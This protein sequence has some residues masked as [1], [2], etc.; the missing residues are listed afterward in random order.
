MTTPIAPNHSHAA[1]EPACAVISARHNPPARTTPAPTPANTMPLSAGR[2]RR[3]RRCAHH[4]LMWI[5]AHA[6]E[7]PASARSASHVARPSTK[8]IA[9]RRRRSDGERGPDRAVGARALHHRPKRAGQV[10]EIVRR[11]EPAAFRNRNAGVLLHHR[12]NRGKGEAADALRQREG[13]Q[14]RDRNDPAGVN[15]RRGWSSRGQ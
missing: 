9:E 6:L 15:V 5:S 12:Q 3:S 10:A 4:E 7:T 8:P 14:P 1:R 13:D 11:R 2:P